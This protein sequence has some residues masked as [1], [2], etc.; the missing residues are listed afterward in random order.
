MYYIALLNQIM[1]LQSIGAEIS[2][3]GWFRLQGQ[4]FCIVVHHRAKRIRARK[5]LDLKL[6][7]QRLNIDGETYVG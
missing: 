4:I 5:R 3:L 7:N 2:Y 1:L 6:P